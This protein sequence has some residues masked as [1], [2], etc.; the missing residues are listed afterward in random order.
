M[1]QKPQQPHIL[2]VQVASIIFLDN[3]FESCFARFQS[4][5]CQVPDSM[6][7]GQQLGVQWNNQLFTV[8]IP[9]GC[10]SGLSFQVAAPVNNN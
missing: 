5:F 7:S 9:V 10:S 3:C 4:L 2:T 1:P 6:E 8:I